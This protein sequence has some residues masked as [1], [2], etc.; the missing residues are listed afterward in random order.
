MKKIVVITGASSGMGIEFAR[1]L[2][3]GDA[4]EMWLIARRKD[5]LQSLAMELSAQQG[6]QAGQGIR[7]FRVIEADLSVPEGARV[8]EELFKAESRTGGLIIDTLVNNAGYGAY[9]A[10]ENIELKRQLD[11]IEVNVTS[12]TAL[13]GHALPYLVRGSR[14]IN[15]SS[16]AGFAALGNFA[17]YGATKAYVLSFSLALAAETAGKGIRVLAL[18]PG[19]VDTE[20]SKVASR[21]VREKVLHGKSAA[22]VV[23]HCLRAADKN[24][25]IA[26]M[27]LKWKAKAFVTRFFGRYFAAWVTLRF[28]KRP[29]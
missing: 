1:Q 29:A 10:F 24:K 25:H 16:L 9:G 6:Q 17:V 12:L 15:T 27:A 20:F 4:D 2:S 19:P 21:G 23:S 5:R 3:C 14:I 8:I 7:N 18:C 13:C 28:E 26:M 11:M 22:R